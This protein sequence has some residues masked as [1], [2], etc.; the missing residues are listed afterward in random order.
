MLERL[1]RGVRHGDIAGKLGVELPHDVVVTHDGKVIFAYAAGKD[2]LNAARAAIEAAMGREGVTARIV[3][4][5]WDEGVDEWVQVD[6]PLS[7]RAKQLKEDAEAD[8]KRVETRTLV[9]S[10][11][12][13]VRREIEESMSESA[14]TLN[15]ELKIVEHPHLLTCQ[16]LFEVTGAKR[17][18]DEF[19]AALR[20]EELATLRT[21][22]AVMLSPL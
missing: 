4:S 20:A 5:R 11:G 1:V 22:R 8:G 2:A 18:L 17:K 13:L 10:A 16:V 9:A 6:P 15:L 3:V 7:G 19:A 14:K 12:R 21:E